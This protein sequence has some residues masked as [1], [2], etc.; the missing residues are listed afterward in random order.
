MSMYVARQ[1][2]TGE[3]IR[4]AAE[5]SQKKISLLF[6][7]LDNLINRITIELNLFQGYVRSTIL[8][9]EIYFLLFVAI[10]LLQPD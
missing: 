3:A 4:E 2:N 10:T 9:N 1:N 7:I 8:F 5:P 6:T